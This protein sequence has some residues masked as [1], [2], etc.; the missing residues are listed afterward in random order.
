MVGVEIDEALDKL[1]SPNY[2]TADA[3]ADNDPMDYDCNETDQNN[4]GGMGAS[5]IMSTL[6]INELFENLKERLHQEGTGG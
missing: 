2:D 1:N 4:D 5:N 6:N 3:M